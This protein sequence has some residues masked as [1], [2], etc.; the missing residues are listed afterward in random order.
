MCQCQRRIGYFSG[1]LEFTIL[2]FATERD[3][4]FDPLHICETAKQRKQQIEQRKE[5]AREFKF[6]EERSVSPDQ[7]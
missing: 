1:E 4:K 2:A 6:E 7:E 5:L 3:N